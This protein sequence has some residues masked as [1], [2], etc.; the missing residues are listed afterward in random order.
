MEKVKHFKTFSGNEW[1]ERNMAAL[2]GG[3]SSG[4]EGIVS[5]ERFS[6]F[7]DHFVD[8][9]LLNGVEIVGFEPRNCVT[10]GQTERRLHEPLPERFPKQTRLT[11]SSCPVFRAR[12][13]WEICMKGKGIFTVCLHGELLTDVLETA[14]KL[15]DWVAVMCACECVCMH[16]RAFEGTE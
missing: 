14:E 13:E 2:Y 7:N 9:W 5:V 6:Y 16:A 11:N 8:L 3:S 15:H 12:Q 1:K 10:F 4:A